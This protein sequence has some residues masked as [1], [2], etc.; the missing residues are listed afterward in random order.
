MNSDEIKLSEYIDSLNKEKK[1]QE[2]GNELEAKEMEELFDTVRLVRSLK[3]P[4]IPRENYYE[5]LVR[6]LKSQ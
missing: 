2:H 3:E 1:P 4:D 5:E 6:N